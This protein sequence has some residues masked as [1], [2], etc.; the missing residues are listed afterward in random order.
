M[1]LNSVALQFS[2]C[3]RC[4]T[5]STAVFMLPEMSYWDVLLMWRQTEQREEESDCSVQKRGCPEQICGLIKEELPPM[6]A[7]SAAS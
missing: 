5:G 6:T 7:P 4:L 3:L 2:C 1:L